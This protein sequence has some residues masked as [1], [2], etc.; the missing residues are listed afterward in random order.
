MT[1]PL[2]PRRRLTLGLALVGALGLLLY[3]LGP[4]LSPFLTAALLAYLGDPLV[5]RLQ[6]RWSR[7]V[8][9]L[10]VFSLLLLLLVLAL[11]LL[12][13]ALGQQLATFVTRLP[14]YL[15]WG[16][17]HLL[18]LLGQE[19]LGDFDPKALA[20]LIQ[21]HWGQAQG[22]ATGLAEALLRSGG[23]LLAFAANLL[24]VPVL[25]F[26][27][28]RD[29]DDLVARLHALLPRDLAPGLSRLVAEVDATLSGFLRGQLAVMLA[30]GT[31]YSLG[32]WLVGLDLALFFGSFAGLVSFVPY[33]GAISG[34]LLA[35]GA[36]LVQA[37]GGLWTLGGVLLVFGLG[38]L[39]ESFW[40]TP[41]LVGDRIGL[42]P[43]AV[44]FAVM[45]GGELFG[46]V[47]VLVALPVA[48]VLVVLFQHLLRQYRD[49]AY[50][51]GADAAA[52][53]AAVDAG[54]PRV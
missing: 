35:G 52:D 42:H 27:L 26:Y 24:L 16:Q 19:A 51:R 6:Q 29:W 34:V 13:P 48:A 21:Q 7:T 31:L 23:A 14:D 45:A 33:L 54:E 3:L 22:L 50:Y 9:V 2:D 32:L 40:L 44:I 1:L 39:I 37:D 17:R 5:D 10:L 30:L 25:T 12:L 46:F 28:L 49:S 11:L 15:A 41:R 53:A 38:Q 20:G 8:A 47:G 4:V 43:V 36:A 18:G